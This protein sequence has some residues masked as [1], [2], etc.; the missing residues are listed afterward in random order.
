MIEKNNHYYLLI[1]NATG[2]D[3]INLINKEIERCYE[4][5]T[6]IIKTSKLNTEKSSEQIKQGIQEFLNY[7]DELEYITNEEEKRKSLFNETK[8]YINMLQL[9][10][11]NL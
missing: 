3:K 4:I 8:V 9:L 6:H 10:A 5:L 7:L 11:N 2:K 1:K